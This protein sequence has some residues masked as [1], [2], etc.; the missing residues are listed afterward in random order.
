MKENFFQIL[1]SSNEESS[2][3]SNES[4]FKTFDDINY[5]M[6]TFKE[7]DKEF[8]NNNT[9]EVFKAFSHVNAYAFKAD[10]FRYYLLYEYG[11]W[12]SDLNNVFLGQKFDTS[13]LDFY[14]F[15][16]D[17]P[18]SSMPELFANG[19]LYCKKNNKVIKQALDTSIENILN[20]FYGD[21]PL[22]VTGP[23]VIGKAVH[24]N[25][26]NIDSLGKFSIVD[27]TKRAY[28]LPDSTLFAYYKPK[29]YFPSNSGLVG[30]NS[31]SDIWSL[32][33]LYS[34]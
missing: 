32:K 25:Y 12:Y 10:V 33:T 16:D 20:N 14:A 4:I 26:E 1:L 5:K 27:E 3:T 21:H 15:K 24:D 30:G 7:I 29:G 8:Y 13:K 6:Y 18:G 11:G 34:E 17:I 19:L 23:S 31:Y 28:S 2:P 22:N 9:S